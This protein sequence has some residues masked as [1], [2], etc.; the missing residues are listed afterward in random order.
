MVCAVVGYE[1]SIAG[2]RPEKRPEKRQ[3]SA[4]VIEFL[5]AQVYRASEQLKARVSY[6]I[7]FIV[8][9]RLR[10]SL[11]LPEILPSPL[12]I[13]GQPDSGGKPLG[14]LRPGPVPSIWRRTVVLARCWSNRSA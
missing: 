11:K 14:D 9:P 2:Q 1:A 4:N 3:K 7:L 12:T 10:G 13:H 5:H 8:E 6:T